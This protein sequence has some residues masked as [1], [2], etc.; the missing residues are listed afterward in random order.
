MLQNMTFY[1][2]QFSVSSVMYATNKTQETGLILK[3]NWCTVPNH[4]SR[5]YTLQAASSKLKLDTRACI[6][7]DPTIN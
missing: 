3:E 2:L 7:M 1:I 5:L 4:R 6:F